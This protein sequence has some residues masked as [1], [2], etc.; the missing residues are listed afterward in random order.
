MNSYQLIDKHLHSFCRPE[1]ENAL[2]MSD[3]CILSEPRMPKIGKVREENKKNSC[4]M[5]NVR[6]REKGTGT[7][8]KKRNQ[9]HL[10]MRI[11]GKIRT[12][13]LLGQDDKSVTTCKDAE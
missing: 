2:R 1:T 10:K 5:K 12:T 8:E 11:G 4:K 7:I 9:F 3:T 6:N 13:L